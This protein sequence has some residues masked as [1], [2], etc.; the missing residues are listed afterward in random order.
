VDGNDWNE[1]SLSV[2]YWL[3]FNFVVVML[4]AGISYV[5]NSHWQTP[6]VARSALSV[7]H[8]ETVLLGIPG[9][10]VC[11]LSARKDPHLKIYR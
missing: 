8:F 1:Q 2:L 3:C 7:F 9:P 6:E 11:F 4:D 10:V 5:I